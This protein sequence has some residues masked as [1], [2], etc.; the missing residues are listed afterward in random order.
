MP[1]E[2]LTSTQLQDALKT[3]PEWVEA[4]EAVQRTFQFKDFAASMM[5]VDQVAKYAEEVQ[6]HPDIMI[7]YSRV[8]LTSSTHDSGGITQNDVALAK[9]ADEIAASI[10]WP[11]PAPGSGAPPQPAAEAEPKP[12][13]KAGS[14]KKKKGG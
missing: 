7:R 1:P 8:T 9:R 2:K 12:P 5:F 6:H 13:E 14:G 4:G 10:P 3:L 11:Q